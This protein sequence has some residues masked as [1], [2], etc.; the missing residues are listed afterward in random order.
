MES[1]KWLTNLDA[2]SAI[3]EDVKASKSSRAKNQ[4]KD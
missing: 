4:E 1:D 3:R 2:D